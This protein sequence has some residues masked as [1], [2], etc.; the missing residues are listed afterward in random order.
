MKNTGII[1]E[2]HMVCN[3]AT[4]LH[5][6]SKEINKLIN[7]GWQPYGDPKTSAYGDCIYMFQAMVRRETAGAQIECRRFAR[8]AREA[9]YCH[10]PE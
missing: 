3:D 2:Y 7:E 4:S 1:T 6:F 10:H 9:E 8:D 5:D